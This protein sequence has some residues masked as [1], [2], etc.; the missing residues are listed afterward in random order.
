MR[1]G[2]TGLSHETNTFALERNDT[3][4]CARIRRG[5]EWLQGVHPKSFVGGFV[6]GAQR[7]DV[8]LVPIATAGFGRGGLVG[9]AVFEE[10]CGVIVD[11]LKAAGPLDGV[12]FALHGDHRGERPGDL[13]PQQTGS[14][15]KERMVQP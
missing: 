4:D 2:L 5:G 13:A 10:C 6:E 7:D 15:Q 11:G 12:Y 14:H 8:E 1:I 3:M 9:R